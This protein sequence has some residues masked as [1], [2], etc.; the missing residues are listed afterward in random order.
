MNA[1]EEILNHFRPISLKE[2]D[3][4]QLMNR[5]DTK[6]IFPSCRLN[7]LLTRASECYQILEIDNQRDFSYHT[8]YL[9]TCDFHFYNQHMSQKPG[10]FKV[11]Y[12]IYEATGASFLEVKCKTN[13]GRTV[14]WR[15]KNRLYNHPDELAL[16]FLS[17][18]IKNIAN[19]ISPVLIN[20]FHRITL[21]GLETKERITLD[22]NL[23]FSDF[24]GTCVELPYLAIAE[25]KREGFT[26]KS[27]LLSILKDMQIRPSG[28]SK[29]C[30]GNVLLRHMPKSNIM[31]SKLM[32]LRKIKSEM[33]L[34]A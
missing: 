31:K 23:S 14:K 24:E 1:V 7:E 26:N 13:K 8:T 21:V 17:G 33:L 28:F 3:S 19:E 4:V 9:D 30:I 22:Y 20:R 15:I 29:F 5:T 25:L 34:S 16:Q 27:P 6:F 11:R 18:H 12:R 2:M 32:M 10:R